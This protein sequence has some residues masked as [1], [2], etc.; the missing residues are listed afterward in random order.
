MGFP[1]RL[2]TLMAERGISGRE[3]ARRANYDRSYVSL[4]VNGKRRPSEQTAR[5]L[6]DLLS[7]QGELT[8]LAKPPMR[9]RA[10]EERKPSRAVEAVQIAMA[11]DVA[12]LDIA[13]DG[14]SE[15]VPHYAQVVAVA[16]SVAV[17]DELLRVRSFMGSLLGSASPRQ[18]S[19]LIVTAGW[20]SSLLAI[21]AANIGDPAAALVWCSDTERRGRHARFPELLGW[22]AFTRALIAYY[23]GDPRRSADA[24]RRGQAEAPAGS[25]AYARLAAQ[26][27]RSLAMLGD[28]E[29]MAEAKRRAANAIDRLNCSADMVGVYSIP[30]AE[31]P[32]Y[33][34]TSLLLVK[35]F[36]DAAKTVRHLIETAYGS[37]SRALG[38]QPT[39]YARTLLILGLAAAGVG[40]MDEAATAG[41]L[42]LECSRV[43][44][45]T[46]VLAGKLDRS[47]AQKAAR[48]THT[49]DYHGRYLDAARRLALPASRLRPPGAGA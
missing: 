40:E 44:W 15:L 48:A 11:G 4:L 2:R 9:T 33:T 39:N 43:V 10:A 42:A 45:P 22:A 41:A 7:A 1:E 5:R 13:R 30:Y 25:V 38:D 19:D 28:A 8:A 20:L 27:M 37:Q 6:D 14:L 46:M 47:L 23:Q 36:Q 49:A 12:E 26:E 24:A 32:P 35:K 21:A 16:P 18:S 29:G 31:D 3:L 34:A 17:Y